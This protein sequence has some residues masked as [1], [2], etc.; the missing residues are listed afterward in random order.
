[1]NDVLVAVWVSDKKPMSVN[2]ARQGRRFKTKK[3]KNYR[4]MLQT[5]LPYFK[6]PKDVPLKVRL[7]F[8]FSNSASDIDNPIKPVLDAIQDKYWINDK[9]VYA[10]DVRKR[11]VA[12]WNDYFYFDIMELASWVAERDSGMDNVELLELI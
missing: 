9:R 1:M 8:A 6:I 10:L 11:I 5:T 12:R 7:V 3:Y 4:E 2:E